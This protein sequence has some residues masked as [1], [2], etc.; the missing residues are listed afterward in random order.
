MYDEARRRGRGSAL[1]F[2]LAT[3]A[4]GH[5]HVLSCLSRDK[6]SLSFLDVE[7]GARAYTNTVSLTPLADES[8]HTHVFAL[9]GH[10]SP[11]SW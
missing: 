5:D 3:L 1:G 4:P 9:P 2:D 11:R 7:G 6:S 8:V 10:G